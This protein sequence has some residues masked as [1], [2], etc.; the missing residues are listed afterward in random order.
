MLN[1]GYT[2]F[3]AGFIA[4]FI[5][6]HQCVRAPAMAGRA[7]RPVPFVTL[8]H[9]P[10]TL[11]KPLAATRLRGKVSRK[12]GHCTGNHCAARKKC[13]KQF[14]LDIGQW[15]K[16]PLPRPHRDDDGWPSYPYD[17]GLFRGIHTFTP[18]LTISLRNTSRLCRQH[19][20][21]NSGR[22]NYRG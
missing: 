21:A 11:P 10:S 13:G 1:N 3:T 17:D 4:T 12:C 20:A 9:P 7:I 18:I 14:V 19:V 5:V 8:S 6:V 2:V 16:Q 22:P 15:Q